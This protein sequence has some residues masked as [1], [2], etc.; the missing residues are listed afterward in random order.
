MLSFTLRPALDRAVSVRLEEC[1]EL[2]QRERR[3]LRNVAPC[4]RDRKGLAAQPLTAAIR[5]VCACQIP[6]HAPLHQRALRGGEGL[7]H[8]APGAS[9]GAHITG[10]FLLLERALD[11]GR[12][13]ACVYRNRGLFLREQQPVTVLPRQLAP[14]TVD[15]VAERG[16]DVAQVLAVPGGGPCR[17]G[18]LANRQRLVRDHGMLRGIVDAAEAVTRRTRAL[19]RVRRERFRIQDVL[20]FRVVARSR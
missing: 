2:L 14:W 18:A 7:Q 20:T 4:E 3:D 16:D 1:G 17:E 13:V 5:T 11:L 10:F 12:V 6:R 8:V 15:V 9:E 19:R